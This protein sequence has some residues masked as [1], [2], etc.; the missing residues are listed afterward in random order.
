[1][2]TA[3][4]IAAAEPDRDF[5]LRLLRELNLTDDQKQQVRTIVEQSFAA[6]KR[7]AKSCDNLARRDDKARLRP[8]KRPGPTLHQQ[9]RASMKETETKIDSVLTAEQKA[10][11]EELRKQRKTNHDRF[12]GQRRG[13]RG[14]SGQDSPPAQKPLNPL[15]N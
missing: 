8:K 2:K 12:G 9:M 10:K 14:Q 11:A 15:S 4:S 6:A 1:V 7:R 3:A 13:L 5:G